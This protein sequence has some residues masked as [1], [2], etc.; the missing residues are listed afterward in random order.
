MKKAQYAMEF[1]MF[2]A[3][4][5]II[6]FVWLVI[7]SNL[8]AESFA[9]R[10]RKAIEDLGKS[11][12]SHVSIASSAYPG[13]R[14]EALMIPLRAGPVPFIINNSEYVIELKTAKG[15]FLFNIPYT[16]GK[17]QKGKNILWN[18]NGIVAIGNETIS[19]INPLIRNGLV[20]AVHLDNSSLL[21]ENETNLTG[22]SDNH[23]KGFCLDA[24][25]ACPLVKE[26]KYD[27]ARDFDGTNDVITVRDHASLDFG[28]DH[29]TISLWVKASASGIEESLISKYDATFIQPGWDVRFNAADQI[30]LLQIMAEEM[31]IAQIGGA[32]DDA[33]HHVAFAV[34]RVNDEVTAYLDNIDLGA[35]PHAPFGTLDNDED[36]LLG[37]G[38]GNLDGMLDE[39]RLYKRLLSPV[40]INV[41][42]TYPPLD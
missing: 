16:V 33:W 42:A 38:K 25:N 12:Q 22:I 5:S 29:F 1:I 39:I 27:N 14:S 26:G 4:L 9:D 34:D 31:P 2:F 6:F 11:I 19:N 15:D 24:S 7:Y 10:D 17:L 36:L 30:E 40:E 32:R 35:I 41:L 21:D 28:T 37:D 20:F 13:Y 18:I 3:I 8:S 23:H